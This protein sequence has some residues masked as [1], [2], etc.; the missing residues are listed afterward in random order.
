MT[1]AG[2]P[3]T[4]GR[5]RAPSWAG[6]GGR[7]PRRARAIVVGAVILAT[8]A[9]SVLVGA[10]AAVA[11]GPAVVQSAGNT[12]SNGTA[13]SSV[14][15]TATLGHPC[16]AGDT[17]VAFVT[18]GQQVGDAGAVAISPPGWRRLYEHS[19]SAHVAAFHAW[20]ALS[21]CSGVSA[22]TFTVSAPGDPGGTTGTVVLTEYSGLPSSLQVEDA[23]NNGD[24]GGDTSGSLT[25][26][27][28]APSGTVVLAA[29]SL[30]GSAT[31]TSNPSGWST[32]SSEAGTLPAFT[33]WRT[34]GSGVPTASASWT[35][36][37]SAW[38]MSML[39]LGSGPAT[40]PPN[41]V[42]EI[43]GGF[44][45]S[46]SWSLG[47]S[48]GVAAGDALVATV[49][50]DAARSGQGFEATTL[51]GGGVTWQ[52]V[53]GFGTSGGGTAEI[54]AGF[55]SAGTGST[56]VTAGLRG[57]ADGEMVISEVSGIAGIDTTSTA[58]GNSQFPTA[59]PLTPSAG[60]F[61][62]AGMASPASSLQVHPGPLWST[63]ST[64][65]SAA[66]GAEWQSAAPATSTTPQWQ[67]S[68][69]ASWAAVVAAFATASGS[70]LSAPAVTG[71][72]PT[73]GSTAGGTAITI[74]GTSFTGATAVSVG[75]N[76]A[77]SF[78]AN[79]A[80]S[81]TATVPAGN[82]GT[83]DVTV[84]TPAGS[85]TRTGADQFTYV[86][87]PVSSPSPSGPSSGYDLV[88]RD[89]G[90]FVFPTGQSGGYYGSL[91]G[92]GV[93]VSNI[94]GMVPS[95][96]DHGYFL[97][98]SDGGVFAFGNAPYLG[99]L[100]GLKVSVH[101]I[102]G[103]V[104][105]SDNRGY[106]LVGAD[107]GVFAFGSAPYLGSLPGQ[108]IKVSDV[109]GIAATP[110]DA[111]YWVVE[112]NGTVHAFGNAPVL[113][114]ATG[115]ASPVA[116]ISS[117]PSGHG[118]WIVTQNGSVF[119]FGDASSDGSLPAIGVTPQHP[120]IGLVPTS[121]DHG[122]WLIG[123]DGGIFAFGDAPFVGSLPGLG[124]HVT[125]I[126]GAVPTTL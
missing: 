64:S 48:Q 119:P 8:S 95:P 98:G 89:G 22:A 26:D 2:S 20:F 79:S 87:S 126:V 103:I 25:A 4:V 10:P 69:S 81:I 109:I 117:T 21:G 29:L 23:T 46:A 39:V 19:P 108:G 97:V 63:F 90:V 66:Y 38:E 115:T 41:V 70:G 123:G 124:V 91:P 50:S 78:T 24:G 15:I 35:P 52:Q 72:S 83:V 17:L 74:T 1:R 27:I 107:G 32:V 116:G 102:R 61:L 75:A 122:Y 16:S 58:S 111:G 77:E 68:S 30:V 112:A 113:G 93:H 85:S 62:V 118:Y 34:G 73:S 99:S 60:D 6:P 13:G 110:S 125:D 94:V 120:I 12:A 101:D 45:S 76:A 36:A 104:P 9:A 80:N 59:A 86:A 53:T 40:A 31:V 65:T 88:G 5:G 33:W 56:T 67:D 49:L 18:V 44:T 92:L 105:T 54:W 82:V 47:L 43:A 11:S 14:G 37:S 106:F 7:V 114:S 96:N 42:Q 71:V 51:T 121:D 3:S 100:P 28:S 57:S 84:V 55:G